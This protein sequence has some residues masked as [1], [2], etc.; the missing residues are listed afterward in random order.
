MFWTF[1]GGIRVQKKAS[2]RT[3]D[4][5]RSVE[6]LRIPAETHRSIAVGSS[7]ISFWN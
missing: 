6:R 3:F 2:R 4:S 1:L 7:R 5:G